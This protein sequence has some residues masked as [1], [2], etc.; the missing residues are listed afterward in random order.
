MQKTELSD[1]ERELI[2][3]YRNLSPK[4]KAEVLEKIRNGI[5]REKFALR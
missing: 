1:D 3:K 5:Q 2:L 4:M